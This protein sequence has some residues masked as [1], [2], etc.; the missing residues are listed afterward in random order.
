M[1]DDLFAGTAAAY[2]RYRPG[3]PPAAYEAVVER[4]GLGGP[5]S[6]NGVLLDLG[7][8][9][10]EVALALHDRFERVVALDVSAEMIEE[11]R[12]QGAQRGALNVEWHVLPAER[13]HELGDG[14]YRLVTAGNAIHWMDKP[15]VLG[16]AHE[17]VEAGGGIALFGMAGLYRP[18]E[19]DAE[20]PWIGVLSTVVH[21]WLGERRRAGDGYYERDARRF[22][23]MLADD[24]RFTEIEDRELPVPHV[25]DVD[26]VIGYL[27]TTSFANRRI[28]GDDADAFERDV[29]ETLLA[30]NPSNRFER[31][32]EAGWVTARR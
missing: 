8:G 15:L 22:D 30:F 24:S 9:A 26:F 2:A 10:G 12:R 21:R 6:E 23:E 3:F 29:R 1:S 7:T 27:N 20:E 31:V 13:L 17:R 32:L 5:P 19:R 16:L 28:L 4:F 25:W 11:A 14:S 18:D